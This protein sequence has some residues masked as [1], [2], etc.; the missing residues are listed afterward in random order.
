M[1]NTEKSEVN[2]SSRS[3]QIGVGWTLHGHLLMASSRSLFIE[4][5]CSI[6]TLQGSENERERTSARDPQSTPAAS[7]CLRRRFCPSGLARCLIASGLTILRRN[8]L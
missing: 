1:E 3:R 8:K 7:R 2:N 4:H 6:P 5:C